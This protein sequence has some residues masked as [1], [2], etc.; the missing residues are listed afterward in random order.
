MEEAVGGTGWVV[1]G[2]RDERNRK[3][4]E[5]V[6]GGGLD[7]DI[8]KGNDG[9]ELG[10]ERT[11]QAKRHHKAGSDVRLQLLFYLRLHSPYDLELTAK[12][13]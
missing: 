4:V 6:A 9:H 2:E 1:G 10:P 13:R 5:G 8:H 12:W 3:E 7:K 11:Q